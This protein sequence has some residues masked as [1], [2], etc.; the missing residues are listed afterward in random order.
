MQVILA[1]R[2][3]A[4]LCCASTLYHLVFYGAQHRSTVFGNG[5]P[6]DAAYREHTHNFS[7]GLPTLRQIIKLLRHCHECL[8]TQPFPQPCASSTTDLSPQV[9][10]RMYCLQEAAPREPLSRNPSFPPQTTSGCLISFHTAVICSLKQL[11]LA[12]VA[13]MILPHHIQC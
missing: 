4:V 2:I 7:K 8:T 11:N 1:D 9:G 5:R 13:R 12:V 3:S 6:L 10:L